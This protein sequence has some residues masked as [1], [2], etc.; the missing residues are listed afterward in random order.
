MLNFPDNP[1]VGQVFSSGGT[2]WLFDSVKWVPHTPQQLVLEKL[3]TAPA[4]PGPGSMVLYAMQGTGSS[5]TL[6]VKAGTSDVAV[7]LGVNIGSGF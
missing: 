2:A 4:A 1:T 6:K 5:G 7:D 3:A